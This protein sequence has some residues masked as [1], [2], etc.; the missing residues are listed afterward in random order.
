GIRD[1]HVTGVQTCALPISFLSGPPSSLSR[2]VPPA[3]GGGSWGHV[4]RR[5]PTRQHTHR[6]VAGQAPR[7]GARGGARRR[8]NRRGDRAA[9]GGGAGERR[10]PRRRG[11]GA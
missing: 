4:P 5:P 9:G 3:L 7:S 8:G 1:F 11:R 10:G 6:T 2:F